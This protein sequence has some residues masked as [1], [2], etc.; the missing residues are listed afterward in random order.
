MLRFDQKKKNS[1]TQ[2]SFNLKKIKKRDSVC[3]VSVES[4]QGPS[5]S[6]ASFCEMGMAVELF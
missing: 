6:S 1:V 4:S 5:T 3:Q 2:L